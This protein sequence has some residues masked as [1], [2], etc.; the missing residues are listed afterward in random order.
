MVIN[1]VLSLAI[2]GLILSQTHGCRSS[3][4]DR[5]VRKLDQ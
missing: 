3:I 1:V 4:E 5:P 2:A